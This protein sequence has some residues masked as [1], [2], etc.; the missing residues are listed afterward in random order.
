MAIITEHE[1]DIDLKRKSKSKPKSQTSMKPK[2]QPTPTPP[3]PNPNSNPNS[4]NPFT[5]WFYFTITV[6]VITLLFV[7]LSSLSP[8]DPKAWFLSLPSTLREHH[9]KGRIIKVQLSPNGSPVEVFTYSGG[10]KTS[11]NVLIVHGLGCSSFA[12]RKVV[13]HLAGKGVFAIA[14][15][16]PGSGFSDKAAIEEREKPGGVF[17]GF[18]DVY[19]EIKEKGIFWGFD[20]LVE[21]G[22]IPNDGVRVS[23]YKSLEPLELGSQEVGKVLGQVID[24]MGLAPLHLVLHDSALSM[25]ANWISE[26]PELLKSLTLIDTMPRG[27]ALPLWTLEIPLVRELVLGFNFVFGKIVSSCCSKSIDGPSSEA[28]RFFLNSANGRQSIVGSGK[29]LNYTFL[30]EEWV[31]LDGVKEMP[32]EVLW[33]SSCSTEWTEQGNK[34][35]EAIPQAKFDTHSGGRWPQDAIAEELANKIASFVESLPKTIKKTDEEPLPDHIQKM[36][37]EAK[38]KGHDHDHD[39][40]HNHMHAHAG[41]ADGYGLGHGWDS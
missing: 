10:P 16:L 8:Q 33:S 36:F 14:I 12:F 30:L 20:N 19:Y 35:A 13:D 31:S 37:D 18:W 39:D 7:F 26:N 34:V 6:S 5:F 15:D 9:S 38:T 41:Y 17:A 27:T 24:S 1:D 32:I 29:R 21:N 4:S 3:K 40:G 25:S 23:T 28:Y 11:E 2:Q 22:Y